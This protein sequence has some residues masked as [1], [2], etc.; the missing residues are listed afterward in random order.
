[1]DLTPYRAALA[2][3]HAA[4][5][6]LVAAKR[7]HAAAVILGHGRGDAAD[8]LRAAHADHDVALRAVHLEAQRYADARLRY[9][10]AREGAAHA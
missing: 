8:Q 1:M 7:A 4:A 10:V 6:A 3:M 5:D 9:R 2:E